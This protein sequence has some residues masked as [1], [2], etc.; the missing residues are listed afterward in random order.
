MDEHL[1]L[2][3]PRTSKIYGMI[4]MGANKSDII[5]IKALQKMGL[6]EH[7]IQVEAGVH[8]TVVRSFMKDNDPDFKTSDAPPT[9]DTQHL[10]DRINVLEKALAEGGVPAPSAP[11]NKP[12]KEPEFTNPVS[13]PRSRPPKE[14]A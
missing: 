8:H 12:E 14:V 6:D 9:A 1:N 2:Q 7:Q 13:R 3:K 5:A 10:H 4:K 11:G